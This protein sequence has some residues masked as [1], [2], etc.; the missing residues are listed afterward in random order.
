M[1]WFPYV[2]ALVVLLFAYS[3]MIAY[4]YYGTKAA[5]YLFGESAAVDV[6][7]KLFFLG[8]D[9]IR[10]DDGFLAAGRLRRRDLLPDG[11]AE[12]HRPVP[13]GTGREA[14]DGQLLRAPRSA[15]RSAPTR[16]APEHLLGS[17]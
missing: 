6:C 9:H 1:P 10:R 17:P 2:L 12:H 7:Y 8:D 3:T 11:G 15:A 16:E 4:C 13:A 5:N 14:R